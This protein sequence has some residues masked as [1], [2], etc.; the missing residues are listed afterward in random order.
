MTSRSHNQRLEQT[1]DI[2]V[3]N[4]SPKLLEHLNTEQRS[5]LQRAAFAHQM[6]ADEPRNLAI[7]NMQERA[8]NRS[9]E[10]VQAAVQGVL[11]EQR[12]SE[13]NPAGVRLWR[14]GGHAIVETTHGY[15]E[16]SG[17]SE[18][19]KV[20]EIYQRILTTSKWGLQKHSGKKSYMGMHNGR[21][22]I[23]RSLIESDLVY[24]SDEKRALI[25]EGGTPEVRKQFEER[26]ELFHKYRMV[27]LELI[28][29]AQSPRDEQ[30]FIRNN[31]S[32]AVDQ[33][34][35]H[36]CSDPENA[37]GAMKVLAIGAL[38]LLFLGKAL[39]DW[40]GN[41]VSVMTVVLLGGIMALVGKSS[42]MKYLTDSKFLGMSRER[43]SGDKAK[44]LMSL[45]TKQRS[46][47][48]KH[49][50]Q[51]KGVTLTSEVM[52]LVTEP[53]DPAKRVPLEIAQIFEGMTGQVARNYLG[54]IEGMGKTKDKKMVIDF[55]GA[56]YKDGGQVESDMAQ[57]AQT[58]EN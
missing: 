48:M 41:K 18:V 8:Q 31:G 20:S 51:N 30:M 9:P 34:I 57:L 14:S 38:T 58:K 35:E 53:K 26:A 3:T 11:T 24:V 2:D 22:V 21:Y 16:T 28:Q 27:L 15:S 49:F 19:R 56:N 44:R 55:L 36:N 4:R 6:H 52:K 33:I 42:K 39:G 54:A 37:K 43:L 46:A 5:S 50:K 29:A 23:D 1:G 10:E 25:P 45:P 12:L 40:N 17:E 13:L 32:I 47:L 7:Q